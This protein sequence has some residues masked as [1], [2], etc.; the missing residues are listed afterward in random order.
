MEILRS[1]IGGIW[2][3][4]KPTPC[5]ENPDVWSSSQ[6]D[7]GRKART[8]AKKRCKTECEFV[9]ICLDEALKE[10]GNAPTRV[11]IGIRGGLSPRER[12]KLVGGV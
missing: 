8:E 7:I 2:I 10:E 4:S 12:T 1:A 5:G 9:T 11:R 6:R 3:P